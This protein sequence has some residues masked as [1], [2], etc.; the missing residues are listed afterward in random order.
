M[1]QTEDT[2]QASYRGES[3]RQHFSDGTHTKLKHLGLEGALQI[4]ILHQLRYLVKQPFREVVW[5]QFWLETAESVCQTE[6]LAVPTSAQVLA[7]APNIPCRAR[8]KSFHGLVD[9][10]RH[11]RRQT[12]LW[13]VK[14]I[15]EVRVPAS[16]VEP[17]VQTHRAPLA[18]TACQGLWAACSVQ[19]AG[20]P[21][22][23]PPPP[24]V[25]KAPL[26]CKRDRHTSILLTSKSSTGWAVHWYSN[27]AAFIHVRSICLQSCVQ[28]G[29]PSLLRTQQLKTL[30]S[31]CLLLLQ[32]GLPP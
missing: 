28:T 20:F 15:L 31:H 29:W 8:S 5:S 30:S 1:I 13:K 16:E 27:Q 21:C 6:Q 32:S 10:W 11:Q 25:G 22:S 7:T 24:S 12:L 23:H 4:L 19:T 2:F 17:Q 9:T 26:T 14:H 3:V 18:D